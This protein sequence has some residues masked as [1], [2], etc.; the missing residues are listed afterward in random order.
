MLHSVSI[1]NYPN[2]KSNFRTN[3]HCPE[4]N[5]LKTV[6]LFGH[7][8]RLDPKMVE[9]MHQCLDCEEYFGHNCPY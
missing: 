2:T 8:I 6:R 5:S 9:P 7:G 1:E 4:C 3:I